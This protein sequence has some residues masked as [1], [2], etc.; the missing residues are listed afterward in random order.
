MS[1]E[2]LSAL[3]YL[4]K[5][6]DFRIDCA[7]LVCGG[8]VHE[9]VPRD[10]DL[11]LYTLNDDLPRGADEIVSTLS[12]FDFDCKTR[13]IA[14]LKMY[15]IKA[16]FDGVL[17]SLHIVSYRDVLSYAFRASAPSTY[18]DVDILSFK[19]NFT[20]VYRTW[21]LETK[22]LFGDREAVE[23]LRDL[24]RDKMPVEKIHDILRDRIINTANYCLEKRSCGAMTRHILKMKL[25]RE[26][27]LFCYAMNHQLFGT[28][29]YIDSDLD[30]FDAAKNL[31]AACKKLLL[32]SSEELTGD[33]FADIKRYFDEE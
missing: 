4:R 7:C 28:V 19:L 26:L 17:L 32:S 9:P 20:T 29:K 10:V 14:E 22:F 18:T 30:G 15:S 21:I 33:I 3:E 24:V 5:C 13:Y 2:F 8:A 31:C 6:L 16:V 12:A 1:D 23:Y 11:I 25:F 27:L